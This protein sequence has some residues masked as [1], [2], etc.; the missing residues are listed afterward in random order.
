[1]AYVKDTLKWATPADQAAFYAYAGITKA[2]DAARDAR[3]EQ[4]YLLATWQA[5]YYMQNEFLDDDDVDIIPQPPGVAIGVWEYVMATDTFYNS[6]AGGP[7]TVKK[8]GQLMETYAKTAG[9]SKLAVQGELAIRAA[10]PYWKRN[11]ADLLLSGA[12]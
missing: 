2:A 3:L 11:Q 4:W 10:A 12:I 9:G 8:T 6:E 7:T 5:D 1:M